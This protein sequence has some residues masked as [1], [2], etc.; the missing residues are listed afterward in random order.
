M[1]KLIVAFS[2]C[3][4]LIIGIIGC[5]RPNDDM[6]A[7][8][9]AEALLILND[10]ENLTAVIG[11]FLLPAHL[12]NGT[13]AVNWQSSNEN[14][15]VIEN[16]G[17]D[18]RN[19]RVTQPAV[20]EEAVQLILTATLSK[21]TARLDTTFNV[22][23]LPE[24]PPLTIANII[25]DVPPSAVVNIRGA[26]VI[27]ILTDGFYLADETGF[28]FVFTNTAP[29]VRVGD[30]INLRGN[31]AL[32]QDFSPQIANNALISIVSN[33]NPSPLTNFQNAT[34][35]EIQAFNRMAWQSYVHLEVRGRVRVN[36]T[37][38]FLEDEDNTTNYI[39]LHDNSSAFRSDLALLDGFVV[40]VRI[41]VHS[42]TQGVWNVSAVEGPSADL[43]DSERATVLQKWLAL[44]IPAREILRDTPLNLPTSGGNLGGEISWISDNV[45]IINIA[46]NTVSLPNQ[47]TNVTLTATIR[48]GDITE[49][50]VVVFLVR[51]V[52]V[53]TAEQ[54]Q[55][56][57]SGNTD[58]V[59]VRGTVIYRN[60]FA[61]PDIFV[62]GEDGRGFFF[63]RVSSHLSD[64]VI[65][66][67]LDI[68]VNAR[69]PLNGG[70]KQ[71][72]GDSIYDVLVL[73][74]GNSLEFNDITGDLLRLS[75]AELQQF[76]M[77]LVEVRGLVVTSL[78]TVAELGGN[79]AFN[80]GV[81]I[82]E[83][84]IQLRVEN[85]LGRGA[86]VNFARDLEVGDILNIKGAAGWFNGLQIML[87]D[88]NLLEVIEQNDAYRID[89]AV[90][91]FSLPDI[92]SNTVTLPTTGLF[93]STIEY[94]SATPAGIINLTTFA[95][96]RSNIDVTVTLTFR[97]VLGSEER[98]STVDVIVLAFFD[99]PLVTPAEVQALP[100]GD[101]SL[102]RVRGTVIYRN[103]FATPD[104]FL[105]TEDGRGH[106]IWRA[107]SH[108]NYFV[109]GNE[110]EIVL[111]V[112]GPLN[113]GI[114]QLD[115]ANILEVKLLSSGL[116]LPQF[117]D[118]T[119][120]L[121][122]YSDIELAQFQMSMVMAYGLRITNIPATIPPTTA[123][124]INVELGHRSFV[125]RIDNV[126][127][128]A[129]LNILLETLEIGD[130][131]NIQAP[132]GWFNG[133]Q[134]MPTGP[135]SIERVELSDEARLE[136]ALAAFTIPNITTDL[137]NL[138][139][140]GAHGSTVEYLFASP[141]GIINL[142]TGAVIRGA[143]AV[144][145]TLT[146]VMRVGSAEETSTIDVIVG[147]EDR[148][149][150]VMISQ[151]YAGGGNANA[152]Y[153]QKFVELFNPFEVEADISGWTLRYV[154]PAATNFP[155]PGQGN[156][157]VFPE[158]TIIPARSFFLIG[159]H[160]G[161]TGA[162]LPVTVDFEDTRAQRVNPGANA[163]VLIL[164]NDSAPF[165]NADA[166]NV[167]DL[168]GWFAVAGT[169]VNLFAGQPIQRAGSNISSFIRNNLVNT[170]NNHNDFGISARPNPRNS[171]MTA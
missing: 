130:I 124:S 145:V 120:Q 14:Y 99:A 31:R 63:W 36:G 140:T 113:G 32:S 26:I 12:A 82:G 168:V 4:L 87:F 23:I 147:A 21:G 133:V 142:T 70:L 30:A 132:M 96:E 18:L 122:T 27:G 54:I 141:A 29:E 98:Y 152:P 80:I 41:V 123:F 161:A 144:T 101:T 170:F 68:I 111:N 88:A 136:L 8:E 129:A 153:N 57:P 116:P 104:I 2:T 16:W 138:P 35:G 112:R 109:I 40:S 89:M 56:L 126:L 20:G 46:N 83:R 167:I 74:S 107:E 137:A 131:I 159:I 149:P 85:V 162:A 156:F 15:L 34:P 154:A 125:V 86:I 76:Q 1:K 73:S 61:T 148:A 75:A 100:S 81:R 164:M 114:K 77:S 121:T 79:A 42:F 64:F 13:I 150:N 51:D 62:Q 60:A 106:F 165:V 139:T 49:T 25:Q 135:N 39:A 9:D 119:E 118:I 92:A 7:L 90:A 3:I 127:D 45:A 115:G 91:A 169:P 19:A 157:L 171:T 28:I 6:D 50:F 94:L 38:I 66:K 151:I 146:F 134:F 33:G 5:S 67:E 47:P 166:S 78:P 102:V 11:D 24:L 55:A 37:N 58:L 110:L 69:G 108:L 71:L 143:T 10:F 97:M 103:A 65:G 72:D 128:R 44:E 84:T 52:P 17:D 59:R 93:G 160:Q 22:R 43:T 163:G 158:G 105:Q 117:V 48:V 155:N 53:Y 95:V